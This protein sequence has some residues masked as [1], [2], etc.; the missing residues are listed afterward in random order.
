MRLRLFLAAALALLADGF[1]C[2]PAAG[3]GVDP[4]T[5]S[6]YYPV[7][8]AVSRG[9]NVLYA[10]NSDFD[11]QW[12]GGTI[13]SLD[14]HLIRRHTVMAIQ[15]PT[16]SNLP[17]AQPPDPGACPNGPP[18]ITNLNDGGVEPGWA[19]APPTIASFYMRDS[20]AIGAFATDIQ[21]SSIPNPNITG[22][23]RLFAPVRGDASLT[24]AD[25]I[26]DSPTVAPLPTATAATFAPFALNCGVRDSHRRC[27]ALHRVG[28]DIGQ[29]GDTRLLTMPG[30]PFGM[31]Q[32]D[33]GTAIVI[34]H[35]TSTDTT[36][37]SSFTPAAPLP[38]PPPLGV[39]PNN[40]PAIQFV[41]T[42]VPNGGIGVASVPHDPDAFPE[43]IPDPTVPACQAVFPRP[44][45]LQTSRSVGQVSLVRYYSDQG[46]LLIDGGGPDAQPVSNPYR[47]YIQ[48]EANFT[49]NVNAGTGSSDYA[50][51]IA[52]DPSPRIRCK[53]GITV[54]ASDPTYPALAEACAQ[55]PARVFIA[56]RQPPSLIIGQVGG[57]ITEAGTFDADLTI[58]TGSIAL[59]PGPSAVR[60][61]PVIDSHGNLAL[62]VFIVCF[63]SDEI[64]DYDPD[65]N[66]IEAVIPVGLGPFALAF[67]PFD[68]T[69]AA[70]GQPVGIDP[71]DADLA[72]KT[73]RF[74]Y[75][76]SFTQSY[77]QVIDLDN[78]VYLSP[79][80]GTVVY[81][82]GVPT[83]PKGT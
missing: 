83:N 50:R 22:L 25:I 39:P 69:A 82:V 16:N 47:P 58:F 54:P 77:M 75:V 57:P 70:L 31:A 56:S 73:Y 2:Y 4:P 10:I 12:N 33:D 78:S 27:D 9:G 49:L 30:E 17:L 55:L 1:A 23:S 34:T 68:Y 80:W 62:R 63:D 48:N 15:D 36:L 40:M 13:Q 51:G 11:L 71:R 72:L 64:I 6:F 32:S 44:A 53:A 59:D 35:Q 3:E 52:V 8:L 18:V 60:M 5:F 46:D 38:P 26:D 41:A 81:T 45:F 24:W 29:P 37:F 28:N 74:G 14:L 67:D 66:L 21:L 65:Q 43:C 19:C 76:A 79:T 20:A 7:G 61:A 42:N